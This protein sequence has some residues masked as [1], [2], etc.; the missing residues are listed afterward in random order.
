MTVSAAAKKA[1]RETLNL[2]IKADERGRI[3]RAAAVLGKNRT[4]FV[5]DAAR[6]AANETLLD[7]TQILVSADDFERYVTLLDAV[8]QPNERLRRTLRTASPWE[9]S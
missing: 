1:K 7:Q 5:L 8:P 4:E 6:Q 2:R 3:D 9:R